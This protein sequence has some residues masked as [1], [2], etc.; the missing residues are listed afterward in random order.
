MFFLGLEKRVSAVQDEFYLMTMAKT[1][2]SSPKINMRK[3]ENIRIS[4]CRSGNFP[5]AYL[6][7]GR[8]FT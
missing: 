2:S 1:G 3:L 7:Y 5:L 8:T 6:G 4:A